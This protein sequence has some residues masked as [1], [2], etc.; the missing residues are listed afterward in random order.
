M[1]EVSR[2]RIRMKKTALLTPLQ[3]KEAVIEWARY[4]RLIGEQEKIDHKDVELKSDG[5]AAIRQV[6]P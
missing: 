5:S 4:N 3:V 1:R 6:A 2:E